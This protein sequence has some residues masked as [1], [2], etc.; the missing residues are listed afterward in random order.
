M[1][2]PLISRMRPTAPVK[3]VQRRQMSGHAAVEYTGFEAKVRHYLPEDHHVV[4][5][6][7]GMYASLFVVVKIGLKMR[8]PK[9]V[10]AAVAVV[11]QSGGGF[12]IPSPEDPGFE[13]FIADEA[14]VDKCVALW[15]KE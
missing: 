11:A 15:S 1:A 8:T 5:G 2:T 10:L 13:A 14:N 12:V 4:M 9:P 7:L 6:I 3:F